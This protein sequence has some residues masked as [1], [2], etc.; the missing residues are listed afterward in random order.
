MSASPEIATLTL[1]HGSWRAEVFDPRPDP[2]ALGARY[3]H[4]CYVQQ[5]WRGDRL[6]TTRPSRDWK[7]YNGEGLPEV[8]ERP[9]TWDTALD[10][11]EYLRIGAGKLRRKGNDWGPHGFQ[12]A[13]LRWT[14]IQHNAR[15][16][17]MR[18]ADTLQRGKQ[19]FGYELTR[20][21]Y[22][23]DAG[24]DSL[25][26]LRLHVPWNQPLIWHTHPFFA[27]TDSGATGFTFPGQ[28]QVSG[29]LA[30]RHDGFWHFTD[31]EGVASVLN[32][33]GERG[34]IICHL[35]PQLGGG[36]VGI[37]L[38]RPL[39]HI[40]IYASPLAASPEPYLAHCFKDGEET[41]WTISYRWLD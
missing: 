24:L 41:S 5:L 7:P 1:Q 34:P 9:F 21:L 3:V 20:A 2:L 30:L 31:S 23:H 14:V 16:L 28:P 15:S 22:L 18:C 11:E 33:W 10:G 39:D 40:V 27:Q 32:L 8:F 6:L 38:D 4:G 26:S 36:R 17:E 37:T 12:S 13:P 35:D 25:T 29:P 19:T